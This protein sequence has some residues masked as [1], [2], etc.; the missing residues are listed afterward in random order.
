MTHSRLH[1]KLYDSVLI[2]YRGH[3][4]YHGLMNF[5]FH[6]STSRGPELFPRL[7]Q[8]TPEDWHRSWTK[9]GSTYYAH[10]GLA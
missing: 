9:H 2:L 1:G 3:I 10:F 8:R 4:A 5:L 7:A 6:I